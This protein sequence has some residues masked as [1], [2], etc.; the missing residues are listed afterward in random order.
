M[1]LPLAARASAPLHQPRAPSGKGPI[2]L[3]TTDLH[4]QPD[5]YRPSMIKAIAILKH[6]LSVQWCCR[7]PV[8]A[9][10]V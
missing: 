3:A 2:P 5:Y 6:A 10:V 4:F 8:L 1:Q 7:G 9:E